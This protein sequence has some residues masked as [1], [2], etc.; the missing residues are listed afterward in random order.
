MQPSLSE[1]LTANFYQWEKRG[2]GWQVWDSPV[3]LEPAFEPFFHDAP[4]YFPAQTIDDGRKP[5][6]VSSLVEWIL[7]RSAR[8]QGDADHFPYKEF[9]ATPEVFDGDSAL[10][11]ISV[12]LP[13]TYRVNLENAE[14]FLF[15]LSFC[16][17]PLSFEI[18]GSSDAIVVQFA[19]RETDS[20]QVRQQLE[21]YFPEASVT[22]SNEALRGILDND[23]EKVVIDFGLSQ[24]FMRP[25][26]VV[27]GFEPDPLTGM[28]GAMENFQTGEAGIYQVLFQTVRHPWAESILR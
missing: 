21:A 2:R 19:C 4:V 15:N 7:K 12:S 13:P 25:L 6:I 9:D 8:S 1:Q 11:E 28:V 17:Y 16:S 18:I 24:E 20:I 10:R 5:T 23:N 22:E 26:R 14:Q 3:E 27:R